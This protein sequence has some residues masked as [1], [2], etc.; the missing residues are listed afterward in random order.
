[1][2]WLRYERWTLWGWIVRAL[3]TLVV[4]ATVFQL[5]GGLVDLVVE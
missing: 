5:I 4:I 3:L 1:V 2:K